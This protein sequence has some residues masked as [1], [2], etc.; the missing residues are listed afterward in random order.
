MSVY[1]T[2]DDLIADLLVREGGYVD[3]PDDRGGPT[4]MGI[5]LATLVSYRGRPCT[6]GDMRA[7][8]IHEA[9][10]IYKDMYWVKPGLFSLALDPLT[11]EMLFDT[12]VHS[13]PHRAV[14]LLQSS[15]G[16]KD[17]GVIGP[18]TRSKVQHTKAPVLAAGY[19]AAR[20]MF[21][22]RIITNN[23]SQAVFA[24]GWMKRMAEFINMIPEA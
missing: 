19:I 18:K 3:H 17:D 6:R 22:G 8:T 2:L 5:T 24:A 20:V 15:L 9:S 16:L 21:L 4:N 12:A 13:G 11:Q 1:K 7:L 10:S 23:P 14:R